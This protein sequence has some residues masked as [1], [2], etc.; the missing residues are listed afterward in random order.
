MIY[1]ILIFLILVILII[2]YGGE[3]RI[4]K[5]KYNSERFNYHRNLNIFR[6]KLLNYKKTLKDDYIDITT[7]LNTCNYLLP[8]IVYSY[9]IKIEPKTIFDIKYLIKNDKYKDDYEM[10]MNIYTI[11]DDYKNL[12]IIIDNNEASKE[13]L[14][15]EI[16]ENIYITNTYNIYNDNNQDIF[17]ILFFTKKPFWY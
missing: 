7:D 9:C 2:F 13:A 1:N 14:M 12:Y 8:N 3:N 17:L 4:F 15:V 5:I 6:K 10:F 16:D 11:D